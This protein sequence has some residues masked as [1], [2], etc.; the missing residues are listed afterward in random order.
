MERVSAVVLSVGEPY[1]KRAIDSLSRQSL[2]VDD[3]VLIEHVSPFSRAINEGA[4]RVHTPYF[5]Q[6]DSDMILDPTCVE[7]LVASMRP[8]T[9]IMVGELRD[10][11]LGR[12]VGVKLFRT[13]CFRDSSVPDSIAQDTDFVA[14]LRARGWR[15]DY[16]GTHR[17]DPRA[18]RPTLGEHKPEYTEPYT[19]R[20]LLIE[21]ARIRYRG[22]KHG[23]FWQMG[24][25]EESRHP[26]ALLAQ[27]AFAHGLFQNLERD[28]LRP[29]PRDPKCDELVAY[30]SS[31]TRDTAIAEGLLALSREGRLGDIFKHFVTAGRS[32]GRH[33]AGATFRD[34]F[35]G[36]SG[37][38]HNPRALVAKIA[39]S[40]GLLM[41]DA[42]R[43]RLPAQEHALRN[44]VV[45]GLGTRAT[46]WHHVRARAKQVLA[47]RQDI[48]AVPW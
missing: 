39:L 45:L 42:D 3:I 28:E 17:D 10:A 36:V 13:E 1:T 4:K 19:Y 8:D 15:T 26:M 31:E 27:V 24:A 22:A 23:L 30:L 16:V 41:N 33:Q 35:N 9:G 18:L 25:M 20:K 11:L 34:V 14:R 44:L 29:V 37:A 32:L 38:R 48:P 6:V 40:H 7:T 43:D 46:P 5:V 12:T 47:T 2:P 21:G